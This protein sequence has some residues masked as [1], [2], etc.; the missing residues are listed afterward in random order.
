MGQE[1]K[2]VPAW[3][4]TVP[5]VV[6]AWGKRAMEAGLHCTTAHITELTL[7]KAFLPLLCTAV[8]V[9]PTRTAD[10]EGGELST[11]WPQVQLSPNQKLDNSKTQPASQSP[12]AHPTFAVEGPNQ[13]LLQAIGSCHSAIHLR[14]NYVQTSSTRLWT[15]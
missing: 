5:E 10:L 6:L 14:S 15:K 11:A 9:C 8:A 1:I 4:N 2:S 13:V 12:S 7:L 3:L